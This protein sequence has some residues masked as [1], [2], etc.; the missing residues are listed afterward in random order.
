MAGADMSGLDKIT[1]DFIFV[2]DNEP[3]SKQIVSRIE[4]SIG[5]NHSVALFPKNIKEKDINDMI[6]SGLSVSEVSDIISN[7]TFKGLAAKAKLSEWSRI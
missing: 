1:A 6:M 2:Y 5:Q 3:R 7:N 4:K